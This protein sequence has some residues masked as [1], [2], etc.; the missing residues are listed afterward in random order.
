MNNIIEEIRSNLTNNLTDFQNRTTH[1]IALDNKKILEK[2][3][4]IE[5]ELNQKIRI[6][7]DDKK[8]KRTL[9]ELAF[10]KKSLENKKEFDSLSLKL[11]ET[12][13]QADNM[14]KNNMNLNDELINLKNKIN[15]VESTQ[16]QEQKSLIKISDH[17]IIIKNVS[18]SLSTLEIKLEELKKSNYLTK[19][20][21]PKKAIQTQLKFTSANKN[22]DNVKQANSNE[23]NSTNTTD[24]E[25]EPQ[26][27]PKVEK[28]KGRPKKI[29]ICDCI[30]EGC[31]PCIDHGNRI[32]ILEKEVKTFHQNIG[33]FQ[34]K[35]ETLIQ[36]YYTKNID[37][38]KQ[39]IEENINSIKYQEIALNKIEASNKSNNEIK[40]ILKKRVSFN[41]ITDVKL[42]EQ[43]QKRMKGNKKSQ[44]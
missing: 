13:K 38:I 34:Q 6:L 2:I 42:I 35:N 8:E 41:N 33:I 16:I 7:D 20:N 44:F 14:L 28:R 36:D 11:E 37:K 10:S 31:I 25:N 4:I 1:Q 5:V 43:N 32:K 39:Q 19:I 9:K 18:E 3:S 26:N 15:L 22:K 12:N 27:E 24:E 23:I 30:A 40:S 21:A 17:E 29:K